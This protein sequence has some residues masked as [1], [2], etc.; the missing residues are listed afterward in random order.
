MIR[1]IFPAVGLDNLRQ[2]LWDDNLESVAIL[3]CIPV[4]AG[5]DWR[6]VVRETYIVPDDQ[7]VQRSPVAVTVHPAFGL[8][9]EKKAS[10]NGWSLIYCH[11]HPHQTSMAA[12]SPVDDEAEV[13]LAEYA[14]RRSPGIPHCSLVFARESLAARKLGTEDSIHVTQM[15]SSLSDA[16]ALTSPAGDGMLYDRQIRAF[17]QAGQ[18]AIGRLKVAIVGVG[19]TGSVV[20]QQ[21]AHLGVTKFLLIDRDTIDATNLNRTVGSSRQDIGIAKVA[22]AERLI[23]MLRPEASV[24]T[25]VGDVV[26]EAVA[27]EVISAEFIFCCTDSHASRHVLNQLSYQYAIPAIDMGVAIDAAGPKV[28]FAGHVK[29]LVAGQP[30]LWCLGN[31]NSRQIREEMM[32]PEQRQVDP[33]FQGSAGVVQPSV[34]SIN[35]TVASTA[36]TMFLSM[37][38]G[39]DAPARYLVYD[40][41]RQ[42]LAPV[43]AEADPHC[44]FCGPES[45]ALGGDRYPLPVRR[46]GAS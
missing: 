22:V 29:A 2:G 23:R 3:L 12:F 9:I 11:T 15:D 17:G 41:N 28:R 39:L 1:I 32:S 16:A 46:H 42:R 45:S 14:G 37:V 27:R 26:D 40:G 25:V 8:P 31:L 10:I 36:V 44:N 35:S 21:L 20:G 43:A 6:L 38:T 18:D 33:Y 4:R 5:A 13:A 7:Y 24:E 30:C 19:G 34:I